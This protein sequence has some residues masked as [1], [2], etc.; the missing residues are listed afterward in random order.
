M[1]GLN[2]GPGRQS[3]A[4]VELQPGQGPQ[5]SRRAGER[6]ENPLTTP[7]YNPNADYSFAGPRK[8]LPCTRTVSKE[9]VQTFGG[10]ERGL[11]TKAGHQL[12]IPGSLQKEN[13]CIMLDMLERVNGPAQTDC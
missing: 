3:R 5:G 12:L 6:K 10:K 7:P 2:T 11:V 4:G 1:K 13:Y 9:P 8:R